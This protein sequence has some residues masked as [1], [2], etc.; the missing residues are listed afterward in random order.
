MR[1]PG[2]HSIIHNMGKFELPDDLRF[3]RGII[4]EPGQ[5][6]T[7]SGCHSWLFLVGEEFA[8]MPGG[9]SY[10]QVLE[11][12]PE[13]L[14]VISDPP[15]VLNLDLAQQHVEALDALPRPTLISCRSG[16]RA[17]A[18]A[19]MYSG[20]KSGAD[21]GDVIDAAERDNAPFV[22]SEELKKWVADSMESLRNH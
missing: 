18:V 11:A 17:S 22:Q 12:T 7:H 4:Q 1:R 15:R 8:T 10:Q 5:Y 21:P 3:N 9:M 14:N 20:L 16:P 6:F 19:F 13:A 2:N